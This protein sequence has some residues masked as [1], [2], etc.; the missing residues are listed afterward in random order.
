MEIVIWS[1]S[2]YNIGMSSFSVFLV[3]KKGNVICLSK[4]AAGWRFR[5]E[6]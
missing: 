2:G 6:V 5:P 3:I 4:Q 1:S